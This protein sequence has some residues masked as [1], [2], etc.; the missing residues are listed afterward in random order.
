MMYDD[1]TPL[2]HLQNGLVVQ[3]N[4]MWSSKTCMMPNGYFVTVI[5]TFSYNN[6]MDIVHVLRK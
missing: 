6:Y 2:Y 3:H 5:K 1:I 4:F